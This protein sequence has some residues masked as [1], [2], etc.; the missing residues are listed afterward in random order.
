MRTNPE[1]GIYSGY[2][3]LVESYRNSNDRV[4]HRTILNTGYLDALNTDQLNLIQKKLTAKVNNP[5]KPL[6]DV[7]CTDNHAVMHYAGEFYKRMVAEKRINIAGPRQDKQPSKNG[8]DIQM[9]NSI[10]NKDVVREI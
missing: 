7:P 9:I 3:S 4:C 10:R 5:T 1:T 6:S 8:K 2:Y